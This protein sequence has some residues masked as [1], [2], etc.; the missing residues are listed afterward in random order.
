LSDPT[1]S[2]SLLIDNIPPSDIFASSPAHRTI[3]FAHFS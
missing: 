1:R 2:S 3:R